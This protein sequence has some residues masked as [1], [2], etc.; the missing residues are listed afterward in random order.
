MSIAVEGDEVGVTRLSE[1]VTSIS[2]GA[3]KD[4]D[5][6]IS[7]PKTLTLHVRKQDVVSKTTPEEARKMCKFK[8]PH[9]NCDHSFLTRMGMLIHVARCEWKNEFVLEKSQI[10]R[11]S[12]QV[13]WMGYSNS[14]SP[15]SNLHPQ[16]ILVEDYERVTAVYVDDWKFR[17]PTCNLP[18][19]SERG[20]RIHMSRSEE[21]KNTY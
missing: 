11:R 9:L 6:S 21:P 7:V 8:C 20:V 2:K 4:A 17:C 14:W 18:C 1:R 15:H 3:R 16:T 19:A 12:Y 10:T 13:K 5:M